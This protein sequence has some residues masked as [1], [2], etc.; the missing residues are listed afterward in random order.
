[1]APGVLAQRISGMTS[2]LPSGAAVDTP[3]SGLMIDR[4]EFDRT[5]AAAAAAAGATVHAATGLIALDAGT[6]IARLRGPGGESTLH[7]RML[8]AADGPHSTVARL[9]GLPPLQTVNTRQYT[10]PLLQQFDD[11]DIWL[12]PDYPGG[13]AWLFPRLAQ[14]PFG[15]SQA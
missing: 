5:L 7:Y 15:N 11:T 14:S 6:G 13:Y 10:V 9:L 3:F 12:S 1:V 8:I 4:A 2:V